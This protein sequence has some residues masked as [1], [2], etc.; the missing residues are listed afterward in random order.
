MPPAPSLIPAVSYLR[1]SSDA[2][3][4]S[5]PAQRVAVVAYAKQHGYRIIR[6]YADLGISGDDTGRRLEFQR[7]LADASRGDFRVV[8]CWNQDRFGRFD[9]LEAGYW[10][11]PLRDAGVSLVSVTQGPIDWNDFAGRLIYSIEQEGKNKFLRDLS[12]NVNR[13]QSA[14]ALAGLWS[15]T[16]PFGYRN[17]GDGTLL[18][19]QGEA[20][21]V[22]LVFRLIAEGMSLGACRKE[23]QH[24]RISTAEGHPIWSREAIKRMVDNLA[25]IG[26][27][28]RHKITSARYSQNI[29]SV[30]VAKNGDGRQ[31]RT[32]P[33]A[34]I[35]VPDVL[36]AIVTKA[37]YEAAQAALANGPRWRG[38]RPA[39]FPIVFRHILFCGH[40]G[41]LM[42]G[43][44]AT[45]VGDVAYTCTEH[46]Y[47]DACQPNRTYQEALLSRVRDEIRTR[48]L[49]PSTLATVRREALAV[50]S[51]ENSEK[52]TSA[53]S[54]KRQK[55]KSEAKLR[56]LETRLAEVPTDMV[57]IIAA[58]IR[59]LRTQVSSLDVAVAS[60]ARPASDSVRELTERLDQV[61]ES[62]RDVLTTDMDQ[63]NTILKSCVERIVVTSVLDRSLGT[64]GK[65][66]IVSHAITPKTL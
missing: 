60:A 55:A 8:L 9:L 58:Q 40:C 1:M 7:M 59:D 47:R 23:L 17:Q 30:V 65:Y 50:L 22:R 3:T 4:E 2:Q 12:A 18:V 11:K 21:I 54:L 48:I 31:R 39:R 63:L 52:G 45:A 62:L 10:I 34:W 27:L 24:R 38:G 26:T 15:G 28:R 42:A 56:S 46:E 13:G 44:F 20:D 57:A 37:E 41:A 35:L 49:K 51:S 25:Y 53:E 36:P 6:E 33:S 16:P 5:V 29:G 64:R 32:D 61:I 66:V 43:A 14:R 19:D